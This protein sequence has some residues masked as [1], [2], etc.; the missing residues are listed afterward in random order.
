MRGFLGRRISQVVSGSFIGIFVYCLVLLVTVRE[1][2]E[3]NE[4]FVPT[5]GVVVAVLLSVVGLVL[6]VVF[7][8]SLANTIQVST[9]TADVTRT[10]LESVDRVNPEPFDAAR[11]VEPSTAHAAGEPVHRVRPE[12]PGYVRRVLLDPGAVRDVVGTVEVLVRPGDFVTTATPVLEWRGPGTLAASADRALRA[13]VVV[14]EERDLDQDPG[15]GI[16]QL[17]D[18]ALRALSPGINDP[19]TAVTCLG[20]L[21]DV[22]EHLAGRRLPTRVVLEDGRLTVVLARFGF[23]DYLEPLVEVAGYAAGDPRVTAA[24]LDL[25]AGVARVAGEVGAGARRAEV[26]ALADQLA[27]PCLDRTATGP[28]RDRVRSALAG[29]ARR[30]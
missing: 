30:P 22:L 16:R 23:G 10:T 11:E 26:V 15:Y 1:E 4:P 9:M 8:N 6:L 24:L 19:S 27:L 17:T 13:A 12:R 21:R 29:V 14:R 2:G 20:Y 18:I 28:G 7:I 3:A 5:L 25:L